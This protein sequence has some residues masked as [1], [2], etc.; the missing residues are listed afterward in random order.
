M[1][2]IIK[3]VSILNTIAAVSASTLRPGVVSA[4]STPVINR[5][6]TLD[7]P[8]SPPEGRQIVDAAFQSYS[9]EFSYMQDY[10]GNE[11]N[12]NHFSYK[13]LQNIASISG[14]YPII[15][16]GGSTQNRT[17]WVEN[18][19]LAI[20]PTTPLQEPTNQVLLRLDLLG[21]KLSSSF[22]RVRGTFTA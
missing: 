10:A 8:S 20:I 9:I 7:V 17:I 4:R 13:L 19:T 21:L 22:P 2:L 16:A 11:T 12:P 15:R 6:I 5:T 3:L 18:Q 14:A 1:S